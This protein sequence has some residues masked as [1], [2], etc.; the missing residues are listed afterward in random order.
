MRSQARHAALCT[1]AWLGGCASIAPTQ[2]ALDPARVAAAVLPGHS[3]VASVQ[4]ALG[5]AQVQQFDSGYQV[6]AYQLARPHGQ[7]AEF[8]ILFGPEG[9]VRKTRLREPSPA[10]P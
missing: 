10:Q 9:V 7:A 6:W 4:A 2:P 3:S 8:V 5:P 1:L